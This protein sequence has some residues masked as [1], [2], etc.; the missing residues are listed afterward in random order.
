MVGS[1]P[2]CQK[3]GLHRLQPVAELTDRRE[4]IRN[5]SYRS[6]IRQAEPRITHPRRSPN[7]SNSISLDFSSLQNSGRELLPA[8]ATVSLRE[9]SIHRPVKFLLGVPRFAG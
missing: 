1:L 5:E 7:F 6:M 8:G 9:T 2:G 3:K 4:V